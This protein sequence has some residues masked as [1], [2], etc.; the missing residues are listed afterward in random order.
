[1]KKITKEF[2][3]TADGNLFSMS[4]KDKCIRHEEYLEEQ[5]NAPEF[6]IKKFVFY[7]VDLEPLEIENAKHLI[8]QN[9]FNRISTN[10]IVRWKEVKEV[11]MFEE[12]HD[13]IKWNIPGVEI[14]EYEDLFK[15]KPK[16]LN[17]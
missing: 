9:V 2:Y 1:M 13:M 16:D 14:K 6:T 11:P 17:R 7:T 12:W 15:D 4:E 10:S 5:K 3:Q 8:E